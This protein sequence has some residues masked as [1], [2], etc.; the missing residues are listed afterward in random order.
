MCSWRKKIADNA[1]KPPEPLK[2]DSV[3][4]GPTLFPP[5][6][7]VNVSAL[8]GSLSVRVSATGGS[9][10]VV[11]DEPR[12]LEGQP[13]GLQRGG[14]GGEDRP[15]KSTSRFPRARWAAGAPEPDLGQATGSVALSTRGLSVNGGTVSVALPMYGPE[16]TPLDL[17][18]IVM[19]DLAGR[20]KIEKGTGTVEEFHSKSQDLEVNVSG[21]VKLAKKLE[22]SESNLEVRF[23]PDPEF[24][25]RL[26]LIGS[27]ALDGG[28]RPEGPVVAHGPADRLSR[29]AQLPVTGGCATVQPVNFRCGPTPTHLAWCGPTR[30]HAPGRAILLG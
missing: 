5:G 7:G 10:H 30:R 9:V 18:K 29:Q 17:P 20:L 21:T 3:S 24:Q 4:V 8:G 15:R 25:K 27:R 2:L 12:P 11:A 13:E 26:G 22:Y 28:R 1:D 16:P 14:P 6:V 19:G 23:K